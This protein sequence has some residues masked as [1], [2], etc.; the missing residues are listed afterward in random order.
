MRK[1]FE[2]ISFDNDI[3]TIN[4]V[5]MFNAMKRVV[6][7]IAD[8]VDDEKK[9]LKNYAQ[10]LAY[11]SAY[12]KGILPNEYYV[13]ADTHSSSGKVPK[14]MWLLSNVDNAIEEYQ[15]ELTKRRLLDKYTFFVELT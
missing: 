11:K 3:I 8:R 10:L 13:G 9:L 6:S 5:P 15:D 4:E 2:K 14:D 7:D 1:I 12:I